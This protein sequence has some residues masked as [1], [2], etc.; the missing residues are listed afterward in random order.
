MARC[1]EV[2]ILVTRFVDRTEVKRS[3]MPL[4]CEPNV[5]E[6]VVEAGD[7]PSANTQLVLRH[8]TGEAV[9]NEDSTDDLLQP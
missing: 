7:D 1:G 4:D 5:R 8:Q 6:R 3:A 2:T 9:A